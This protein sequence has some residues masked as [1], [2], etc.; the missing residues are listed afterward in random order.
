VYVCDLMAQAK[1]KARPLSVPSLLLQS[2]AI[3]PLRLHDVSIVRAQFH[4]VSSKA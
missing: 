1:T 2:R 4:L 3:H